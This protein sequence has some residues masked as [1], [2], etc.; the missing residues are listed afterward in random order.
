MMRSLARTPKVPILLFVVIAIGGALRFV[1]LSSQSLWLDEA[2]TVNVNLQPGLGDTLATIPDTSYLPHLHFILVWLSSRIFGDGEFAL[3][4]ISALA[5]MGTIAV[6]YAIGRELRGKGTGLLLAAI[7][8]VQGSLLWYSQEL[9]PYALY[10]LLTSLSF[11]FFLRSLRTE[12]TGALTGWSAASVFAIATHYFAGLLVVVEAAWLLRAAQ[13]RR[14]IAVA[15]LPVAA[16]SLAYAPLALHQSKAGDY[17]LY[18]PFHSRLGEVAQD[19]FD[20]GYPMV[21]ILAGI[22]SIAAIALALRGTGRAAS[23]GTLTCLAVAAGLVGITLAIAPFK[24]YLLFRNLIPVTV[25]LFAAVATSISALPR[26]LGIVLGSLLLALLSVSSISQTLG[27][28]PQRPNWRAAADIELQQKGT[29]IVIGGEASGDPLRYYLT[30]GTQAQG[31][32]SGDAVYRARRLVLIS[33]CGRD[34]QAM[35]DSS[36]GRCEW[37][38]GRPAWI[39]DAFRPLDERKLGNVMVR[40]F[41]AQRPTT[42]N[43]T[44]AIAG[45][46]GYTAFVLPRPATQGRALVAA[47][48][49]GGPPGRGNKQ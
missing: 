21:A 5:G 14:R 11:F 27:G 12:G 24:D 49:S 20:P 4:S 36:G 19:L 17:G 2:F 3:R 10:T 47:E 23:V 6:G 40:S 31:A 7:I 35:L 15:I 16:V 42:V 29:R 1:T 45:R 30:P 48:P 38:R 43:V 25:I 28:D 44:R 18:A 37:D 46:P 32:P 13:H 8:A 22:I 39:S 41:E 33:Q 26:S 9:R 34:P